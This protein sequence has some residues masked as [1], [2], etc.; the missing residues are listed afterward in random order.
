M[1][2]H[3]RPYRAWHERKPIPEMTMPP[4]VDRKFN[5]FRVRTRWSRAGRMRTSICQK[6]GA[7]VVG[8]G[9][10]AHE[11][12]RG[13]GPSVLAAAIPPRDRTLPAL[14]ERQTAQ[15]SD[16]TLFVTHDVAWTCAQTR[17]MAA[18]F[19]GTLRA[20]GIQA[21]DRVAVMCSNR[22][23]F[24]QVYLGC[25]WLGAI[26]VPI[27]TASRGAQLQHVLSNSG[28]RGA[29]PALLS[30]SPRTSF[31]ARSLACQ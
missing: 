7:R 15:Y 21:G 17:E 28:A 26:T 12:T 2:S 14:L 13:S 18:R 1:L 3:Y 11:E 23:E 4:G 30:P 5:S 16:R 24:M 19:A 31:N 22:A 29:A 10:L 8:I 9:M 27:N 25:A 6:H 20:A